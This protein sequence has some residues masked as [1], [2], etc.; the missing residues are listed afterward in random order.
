MTPSS[1]NSAILSTHIVHTGNLVL[2]KEAAAR[3]SI[4]KC[5]LLYDDVVGY[6]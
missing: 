2:C 5:N 3:I 4:G 6:L 1:D